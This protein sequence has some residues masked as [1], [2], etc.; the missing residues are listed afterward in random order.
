MRIQLSGRTR[1]WLPVLVIVIAVS[2]CDNVSWGGIQLSLKPPGGEGPSEN[3]VAEAVVDPIPPNEP[4]GPA[5]L[6][7]LYL[8]E[9]ASGQATLSPILR[10]TALMLMI[11][12]MSLSPML[13]TSSGFCMRSVESSLT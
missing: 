5:L 10:S 2:G 9:V 8:V 12:A 1:A 3:G 7:A 11:L 4:P 13:R 6:P